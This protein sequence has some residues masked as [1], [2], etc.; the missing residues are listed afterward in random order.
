MSTVISDIFGVSGRKL[1]EHLI[2]KGHINQTEVE[3]N[4]HGRM[5]HKAERITESL[6]GRLTEHQI[7]L[8]KH[9]WMHITY[10]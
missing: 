6:F 7:F 9:L 1:L 3:Q 8:I 4:I 10:L 2:P 5:A